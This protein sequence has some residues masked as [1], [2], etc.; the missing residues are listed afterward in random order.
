MRDTGK[1]KVLPITT[2]KVQNKP[3][4]SKGGISAGMKDMIKNMAS[5]CRESAQYQSIFN[6]SAADKY[7]KYADVADTVLFNLETVMKQ[8]P[9]DS[10]LRV[11]QST[12]APN[13]F[14]FFI[15]YYA[16]HYK[17]IIGDI[18][19]DDNNKFHNIK[20][21]ADFTSKIAKENSFETNLKFRTGARPEYNKADYFAPEKESIIIEDELREYSLPNIN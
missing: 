20:L 3:I 12:K 19:F 4:A 18:S 10:V 6:R 17:H 15:E 8:Y 2:N 11:K 13:N 7:M 5:S 1:M 14:R 21:L 16:S 9:A